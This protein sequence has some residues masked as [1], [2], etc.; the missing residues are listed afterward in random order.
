M[1]KVSAFGIIDKKYL[2]PH[3]PPGLFQV[4][5]RRVAMSDGATVILEKTRDVQSQSGHSAG[6]TAALSLEGNDH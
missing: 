3:V 6:W 5:V 1:G 2:R 4:S